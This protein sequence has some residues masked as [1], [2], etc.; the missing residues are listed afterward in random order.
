MA[1]PSAPHEPTN[2]R[3]KQAMALIQAD[4][5]NKLALRRVAERVN[6]SSSRLRHVFKAETGLT[7]AQYVKFLRMKLAQELAA[8]T[9][10]S[11]KEIISQLGVSD[12]SHFLRDFK[13]AFGVTI[14]QYR[15][16]S[17]SQ[18]GQ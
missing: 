11:V 4:L 13:R 8:N 6:L 5:S 2:F 7:P 12:E 16:Q 1:A 14:S 18:N 3:V 15:E 17:R 10:L 9:F